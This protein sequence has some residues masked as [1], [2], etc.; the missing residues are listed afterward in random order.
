MLAEDFDVSS[1]DMLMP[2]LLNISSQGAFPW[3]LK[4][5]DINKYVPKMYW[6]AQM[7]IP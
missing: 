7:P 6:H 1:I 5:E 4:S 2:V 3:S